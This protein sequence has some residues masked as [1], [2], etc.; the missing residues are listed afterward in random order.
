ML[1]VLAA[2]AQPV[3]VLA[4]VL[5][6]IDERGPTAVEQNTARKVRVKGYVERYRP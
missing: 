3:A 6:A 5:D 1:P 4:E 2:P